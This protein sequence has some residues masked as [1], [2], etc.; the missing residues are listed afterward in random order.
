MFD[1]AIF[2]A[3]Y[4]LMHALHGVADYWL[5]TDWQ[6]QNKSKNFQALNTHVLVYSIVMVLVFF[7]LSLMGWH[8]PFSWTGYAFGAWIYLTHAFMDT[9][10][11]IAWFC[12]KTKGWSRDGKVHVTH[13]L[14]ELIR[15]QGAAVV[16]CAAQLP[17][18]GGS[19]P[20][21][22]GTL[23]PF[24]YASDVKKFYAYRPRAASS[25]DTDYELGGW[26][27]FEPATGY[28]REL[29][30]LETAVRLHVTIAMDQKFHYLTL[31][32]AA[33]FLSWK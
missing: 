3:A 8:E 19:D 11:P 15:M 16:N 4:G 12:E 29:T 32:I 23:P 1:P 18:M 17:Y 22:P 20:S 5:Q 24:V 2:A 9:R 21:K 33:L 30:P 10:K 26:V 14:E 28:A 25:L 13:T 6:A 31:A 7:P 27:P